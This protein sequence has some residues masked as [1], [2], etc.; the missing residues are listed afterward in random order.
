M[1]LTPDQWGKNVAVGLSVPDTL[2]PNLLGALLPLLDQG[3]WQVFG[4]MTIGETV[5][6][7][8]VVFSSIVEM[9]GPLHLGGGMYREMLFDI[10]DGDVVYIVDE[11]GAPIFVL[12]NVEW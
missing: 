10:V 5:D 6:A 4:S 2:L 7:Y 1:N 11:N 9:D 8:G 12:L 3:S